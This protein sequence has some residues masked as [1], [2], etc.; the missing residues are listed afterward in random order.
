MNASTLTDVYSAVHLFDHRPACPD[1]N[2]MTSKFDAG[3]NGA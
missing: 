3:V 2:C 1:T